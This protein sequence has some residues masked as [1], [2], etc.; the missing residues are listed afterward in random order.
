MRPLRDPAPSR[1]AYRLNRLML[2]PGFRGF[3]RYGLPAL[4]VVAAAAIWASDEARRDGAAERLAELRRQIET[5]PEFMVRMMV[6]DQASPAIEAEIRAILPVDFPASSFDLDLD[7]LREAVEEIDAVASAAVRIQGGG[8]LG[9][10][11]VERVPVVV[12]RDA[13]GL[14]LLD[15]EGHRVAGLETRKD[16]S[17]L[18]LIVGAGAEDHVI[19]ALDIIDAA[20]PVASRLR[21][22][23]RVGE[24]RW[25]LVLDRDQVVMLPEDDALTAME[26]VMALNHAQDLL[27]RDLAVVDFRNPRRPVLRL[28]EGALDARFGASLTLDTGD[29]R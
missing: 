19:E 21:G 18:P 17:D 25:D 27:A 13:D 8:V 1:L 20:E 7:L 6:V 14:S 16:R 12:W 3:L 26:R 11:V 28:T 5:R 23:R 29:N 4:L 9:V 15:G 2:T 24:R 22:L 10:E